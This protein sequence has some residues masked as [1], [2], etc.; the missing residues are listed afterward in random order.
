MNRGIKPLPDRLRIFQLN[1]NKS[2]KAH[3][4]LINSALGKNWD[5]IL[6]QEPYL[7]YLGHIRTPNGFTSIFPHDR[8]INQEATVRSVIWV[9]SALSTNSWKEVS[10]TRNNDLTA[11]QIDA[12]TCKLTIFNIYN[13]CNHSNTLARLQHFVNEERNRTLGGNNSYM[14]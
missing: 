12:G 5:I 9:N 7:T 14:I 10:I 1:L 13:D 6:I 2:E 8:L 4:D 3:L 11:V